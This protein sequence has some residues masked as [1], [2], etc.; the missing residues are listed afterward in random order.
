[1]N[2]LKFFLSIF[3]ILN[4]NFNT[5]QKNNLNGEEFII[6][7]KKYGGKLYY[8][9]NHITFEGINEFKGKSIP[10]SI[11][12]YAINKTKEEIDF[13]ICTNN[14]KFN[15]E[16]FY[17]YKKNNYYVGT[18]IIKEDGLNTFYRIVTKIYNDKKIEFTYRIINQD[19]MLDEIKFSYLN[20]SIQTYYN[21]KQITYFDYIN[22]T[23][24]KDVPKEFKK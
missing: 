13:S 24:E 18:R 5:V 20:G 2:K 21:S 14:R 19:E 16:S 6:N 4:I 22:I 17:F 7:V 3:Y 10:K 23:N 8:N 9:Y 11:K 15:Y 1:M 12:I